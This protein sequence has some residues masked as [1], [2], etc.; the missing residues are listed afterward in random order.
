MSVVNGE[1]KQEFLVRLQK[2]GLIDAYNAARRDLKERG[3]PANQIIETLRLQP[4]FA[5]ETPVHFESQDMPAA[6]ERNHVPPRGEAFTPPPMADLE[7]D[8]EDPLSLAERFY[9]E[10]SGNAVSMAIE[11]RWVFENLS[12]ENANMD[13][14]PSAGAWGLF[15]WAKSHPSCKTEFYKTFA[16]KLIPSKADIDSSR[17]YFDDNRKVMAKLEA[18]ERSMME[19]QG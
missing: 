9:Q 3:V 4:P 17:R 8:F 5:K 19:D 15:E 18:F 1:S 16:A 12:N 10:K 13:D 2:L 14:C 6:P 7:S 11:V